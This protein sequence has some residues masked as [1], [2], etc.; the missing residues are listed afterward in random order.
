MT[1]A[2]WPLLGSIALSQPDTAAGPRA[3][4]G[5]D[6]G[7]FARKVTADE[8]HIAEGRAAGGG[9]PGGGH[10]AVGLRRGADLLHRRSDQPQLTSQLKLLGCSPRT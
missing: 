1:G 7:A 5:A 3:R 6:H 9:A 2:R 10:G 8:D 4:V